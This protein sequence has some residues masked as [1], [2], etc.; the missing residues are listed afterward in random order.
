MSD[1]I[2][3]YGADRFVVWEIAPN[4]NGRAVKTCKTRKSAENWIRKHA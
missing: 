4:G 3:E 2:S 1:K